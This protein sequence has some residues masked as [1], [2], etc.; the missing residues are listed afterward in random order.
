MLNPHLIMVCLN[1]SAQINLEIVNYF[2][3]WLA[4]FLLCHNF[5]RVLLHHQV[6]HYFKVNLCIHIQ[7]NTIEAPDPTGNS[8]AGVLIH[9]EQPLQT[10]IKRK[11]N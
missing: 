4:A 8:G 10:K 6:I 5:R 7:A 2:V 9:A 1:V 11:V 3:D